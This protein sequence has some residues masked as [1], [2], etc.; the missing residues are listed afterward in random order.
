M[1]GLLGQCVGNYKL[2][3]HCLALESGQKSEDDQNDD[4]KNLGREKGV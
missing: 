4:G 2:E 1:W 3:E